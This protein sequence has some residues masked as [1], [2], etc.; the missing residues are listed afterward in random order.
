MV[1]SDADIV[2]EIE[3]LR[4]ERNAVILAHNYQPPEIQDIADFLGDSLELSLKA[5]KTSADVI[6]FCGV[7]FMAETAK[8]VSPEKTVLLPS[9]ESR[10]PMVAMISPQG[11][12]ELKARHPGVPVM[13][14]VNTSAAVKAESDI[15][16]TS[17]NVIKVAESIDSDTMIFTPDKHLA[18]YLRTKVQKNIIPW[19]GYCPTH[20]KILPEHIGRQK[21]LHPGAKV[22]VHPECRL[23]VIQMA[24]EV[25]STSGMLRYAKE[26]PATEFIIATEKELVYRLK[27]EVPGKRFYPATK[28]AL[29]PSMKKNSLPKLLDS[30]KKTEHGIEIPEDVRSRAKK[31]IDRMLAL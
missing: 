28:L 10:C 20:V 23:D 26:S 7:D 5:S 30:L 8:I 19:D 13:S 25:A 1:Q 6:V 4:E 24:D 15:C 9:L 2:K 11:L 18:N 17:A 22:V 21:K 27:K 29:C 12:R 14:Y 16:C 3:R 31:A